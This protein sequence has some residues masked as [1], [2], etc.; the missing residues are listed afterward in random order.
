[1]GAGY[2]VICYLYPP[3]FPWLIPALWFLFGF[4]LSTAI[5]GSVFLWRRSMKELTALQAAEVAS[6]EFYGDTKHA[7]E[8][9]EVAQGRDF[10]A[11]AEDHLSKQGYPVRHT[12]D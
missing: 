7:L 1:M 8:I 4:Y 10:L 6:W 9:L 5:T 3:I 2:L 11:Y 12:A